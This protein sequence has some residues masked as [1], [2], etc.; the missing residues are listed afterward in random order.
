MEQVE[1]IIVGG[2]QA[3]LS[4][5]YY[6]TQQ[7]HN[8]LI[9][10]QAAQPGEAWRN[11]RWD[12]FTFVT[13]NW[14]IR[15]PGAEY[16]GDDPDGFLPQAQ[17]VAYFEAYVARFFLPIRY[18]VRVTAVV[19]TPDGYRVQTDNVPFLARQ[20]VI[21]TGSFQ[22][23]KIPAFHTQF[24]PEIRQ[25]HSGNYR[26]P[27]QLPAGAVL[28]VGSAQSG[29]QIAEELYQSGRQVYLC[30]GKAGRV[31]RR[32]RGRDSTWWLHTMGG[33]DRTVDKLPSP[34]A[35]FAGNPHVSG[36]NGGHTLNLHQFARDGVTLLGHIRGVD[37]DDILLAGDLRENLAFVDKFEADLLVMIDQYIR[38]NGLDFPEETLP[39]LRDGY[40]Q[41][42][43]ER[44]NWRTADI[45]T[46]IWATG[47]TFDYSLVQLPIFDDDGYPR[48]TRG[49]TEAPGLYF[50][51]LNWLHS[52]KSTLLL[53]VGEDAAHV[54]SAIAA[55]KSLR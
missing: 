44:L 9:L 3:G 15:L 30:V 25:L 8:H 26:N 20:V 49:V 50:V 2:G 53:G 1:T 42:P 12:S 7:G 6:L 35:R 4:V 45:T 32:Y 13:P 14:M 38:N 46:V 27:A 47:Y 10:D 41:E 55:R 29:C 34:K 33:Y 51:G 37:G 24:P 16:S 22:Q 17:I 21:A 19:P 36:K 11:H 23:P 52:A 54:A 48:Q 18:G 43:I 40:T 39:V 5:S 31:P 28:V